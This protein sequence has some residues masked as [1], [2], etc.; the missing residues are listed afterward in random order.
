M[1]LDFNIKT[2]WP[3]HGTEY[4]EMKAHVI[5]KLNSLNSTTKKDDDN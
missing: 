3:N 1:L 5:F 2:V 4:L